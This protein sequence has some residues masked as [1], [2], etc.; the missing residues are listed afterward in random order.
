MAPI[1]IENEKFLHLNDNLQNSIHPLRYKNYQV[2]WY[3]AYVTVSLCRRKRLGHIKSKL[4]CS[5]SVPVMHEVNALS[6]Q[7]FA[8][9]I[10]MERFTYSMPTR[11][12]SGGGSFQRA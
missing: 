6:V 1:R 4:D 3:S 10:V 11:S 7:P 2:A 9:I 8:E 5:K 12:W